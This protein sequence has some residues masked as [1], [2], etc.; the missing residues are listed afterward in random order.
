MHDA[1]TAPS[2]CPQPCETS[3][4]GLFAIDPALSRTSERFEPLVAGPDGL[5]VERIVSWGHSSP[6]NVWY[7]QDHDEW[8]TVLEGHAGLGYA[9]GR[10]V[11]LHRGESLLIPRHVRHRVIFTSSPCLWLAVHSPCL[12]LP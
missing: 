1:E 5:L 11:T 3:P 2:S 9:D 10:E 7:D 8:V 6:E 12:T 4:Q